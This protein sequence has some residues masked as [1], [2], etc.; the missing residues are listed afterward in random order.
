MMLS[1]GS[2]AF[3]LNGRINLRWRQ[4]SHICRA[5]SPRTAAL[6]RE[7]DAYGPGAEFSDLLAAHFVR[8][9]SGEPAPR[10]NGKRITGAPL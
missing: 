3:T 8:H 5:M 10:P 6:P 2:R 9:P 4:K 7:S 1:T